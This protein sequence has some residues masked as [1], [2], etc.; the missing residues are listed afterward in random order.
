MAKR[1]L[2]THPTTQKLRQIEDLMTQLGIELQF[3]SY[4]KITVHD[5]QEKIVCKMLEIEG[6][7]VTEFPSMFENKL[8]IEE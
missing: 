1:L 8:I 2:E 7:N 3:D 6:E 5:K 4:G